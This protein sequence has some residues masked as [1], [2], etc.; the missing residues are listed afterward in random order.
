M[1]EVLRRYR[2]N[3]SQ[4]CVYRRA[5]FRAVSGYTGRGCQPENYG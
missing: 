4:L 1:E 3:V 5:D 2:A